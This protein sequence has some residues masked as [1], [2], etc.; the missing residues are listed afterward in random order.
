[1]LWSREFKMPIEDAIRRE[2]WT[3][4]RRLIRADLK[5]HPQS[6]WLLS[7]LALTYYEK[8]KYKQA[9][10]IERKACS[11]QPNC[12][13]ILWGLAGTLDMLGRYPEAMVIYRRL[14]GRGVKAIAFG[15]CGEGPAWARGL[16]ADCW[17]RLA[18]CSRQLGRFAYAVKCYERHLSMRGPGCRSI[19]QLQTVRRELREFLKKR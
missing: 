4:A 18:N 11:L 6:H 19:Y 5:K 12:P 13:L 16:I 15:D 14:I 8:R 7:R 2:D 17:Y 1:M 3:E 10:A 9:L